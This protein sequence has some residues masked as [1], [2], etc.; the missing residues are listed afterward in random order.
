MGSFHYHRLKIIHFYFLRGI[1]LGK[2]MI[3]WGRSWVYSMVYSLFIFQLVIGNSRLKK[4][5][6][7][8]EFPELCIFVS[9]LN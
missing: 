7:K 3:L 6:N 2:E 8:E 9:G 4:E 1:F 5:D